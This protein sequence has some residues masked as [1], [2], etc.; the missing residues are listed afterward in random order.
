MNRSLKKFVEDLQENI[1]WKTPLNYLQKQHVKF[2]VKYEIVHENGH[3][4]K[5]E[6]LRKRL[7]P[8]TIFVKSSILDFYWVLNTILSF[9]TS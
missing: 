7:K 9:A 3:T 4:S 5:M 6:L 2:D 1:I 8:F